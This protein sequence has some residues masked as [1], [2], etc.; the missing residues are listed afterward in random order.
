MDI[1]A[2]I[3]AMRGIPRLIIVFVY[4][5]VGMLT[6]IGLT[7]V[8]STISANVRLRSREFALLRSVGMTQSGLQRMLN[9]ES[10][11][12]SMKSLVIGVPLG[13]AGSYLIYRGMATPVTSAYMPPQIP[14]LQCVFGVVIVTW[15]VMR[16]SASK[17]KVGSIVDALRLESGV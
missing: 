9:L 17:L 5:F 16:F 7:N 6:L 12:S 13:I 10:V 4:G 2:Q 3:E 11:L 14:I 1:E 8:I 15:V